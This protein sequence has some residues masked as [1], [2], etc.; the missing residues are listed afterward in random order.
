MQD[1]CG[2]EGAVMASKALTRHTGQTAGI[3]S[4][5]GREKPKRRVSRAGLVVL[6]LFSIPAALLF[7]PTTLLLAIGM[8][9]TLVA[10]VVDRD[11]EKYAAITVGP[12]NFCGVLPSAISLWQAGH[13]MSQAV[14]LLAEPLNWLIMYGAAAAGWMIY[15]TLPP[16]VAAFLAH[17]NES[18][19]KSLTEHQE[20]LVEEWGPEVAQSAVN[21]SSGR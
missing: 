9:P 11:P 2:S 13:E 1:D 6:A 14:A 16:A 19:I 4:L 3:P 15:F 7:L 17:R 10:L 12:I 18:E 5:P 21:L 8:V 20:K